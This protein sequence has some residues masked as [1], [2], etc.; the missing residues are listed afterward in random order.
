MGA[1]LRPDMP[2]PDPR[3]RPDLC[4]RPDSR[5]RRRNQH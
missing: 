4:P 2:C 1:Q 3:P 5:P